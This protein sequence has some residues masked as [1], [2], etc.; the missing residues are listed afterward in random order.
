MQARQDRALTSCYD[1]AAI[2]IMLPGLDGL[3]IIDEL[4]QRRIKLPVI[5]LQ[6][7]L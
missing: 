4:R 3:A 2:D 6:N 7:L 5:M 1:A